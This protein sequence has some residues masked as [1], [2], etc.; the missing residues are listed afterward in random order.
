MLISCPA[1]QSKISADGATLQE[2]S[3]FLDGLIGTD[4]AVDELEKEVTAK[5]AERDATIADLRGRLSSAETQLKE[6][7]EKITARERTPNVDTQ[8]T[9]A[10]TGKQKRDFYDYR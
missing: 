2:K 1:C 10:G 3:A 4:A 8:A 5:L 7:N 9:N 6:A